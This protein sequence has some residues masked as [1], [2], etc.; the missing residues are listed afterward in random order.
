VKVVGDASNPTAYSYKR[1]IKQKG[2]NMNNRIK[3]LDKVFLE[4]SKT[5]PNLG[6]FWS[7][8]D[9]QEK[10]WFANFLAKCFDE[11]REDEIVFPSPIYGNC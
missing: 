6:E 9:R 7:S 10:V 1:K 2:N 4:A 8:L 3:H 5:Y 11:D